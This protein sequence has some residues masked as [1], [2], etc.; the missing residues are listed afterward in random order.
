MERAEALAAGLPG[1][2]AVVKVPGAHAANL[3]HPGPVNAAIGEFL[4]GL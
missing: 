2:G 1:A 4:A 3:T